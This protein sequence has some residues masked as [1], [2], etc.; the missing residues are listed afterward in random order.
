MRSKLIKVVDF[1]ASFLLPIGAIVW[2]MV[3][4]TVVDKWFVF[5]IVILTAVLVNN[6]VLIM[7]RLNAEIANRRA[8][9]LQKHIDALRG[10]VETYDELFPFLNERLIEARR[11]LGLKD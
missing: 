6:F 4:V 8:D 11:K 1:T 2:Y 9:L 3:K 10:G 5:D 7:I